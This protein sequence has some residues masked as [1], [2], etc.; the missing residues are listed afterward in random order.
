MGPDRYHDIDQRRAESSLHGRDGES[1]GVLRDVCECHD[2]FSIDRD[3]PLADDPGAGGWRFHG[4]A[5]RR[6]T[7]GEVTQEDGF[8]AVGC[9][10][11][12]LECTHH[13]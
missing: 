12:H 13:R 2:L 9:A 5:D 11:D 10:G 6:A 1:D 7:G 8:H 4:G 3:Q